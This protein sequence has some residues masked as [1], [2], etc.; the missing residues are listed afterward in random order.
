[1]SEFSTGVII[2]FSICFLWVLT[3]CLAVAWWRF[4]RA[5]EEQ[6]FEDSFN[7]RPHRVGNV[8]DFRRR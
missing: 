2:G 6:A 4:V 7:Y 1:M 5:K 8:V 3:S